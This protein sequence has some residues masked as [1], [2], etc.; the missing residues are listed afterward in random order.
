[1][2]DIRDL[3]VTFAN[4]VNADLAAFRN[5]TAKTNNQDVDYF[6]AE[7]ASVGTMMTRKPT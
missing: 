3:N 5:E 1:M 7:V 4:P 6:A 2:S